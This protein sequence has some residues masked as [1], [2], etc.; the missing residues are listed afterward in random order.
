MAVAPKQQF[1]CKTIVNIQKSGEWRVVWG[2]FFVVCG[3][4]LV[5]KLPHP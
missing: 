1:L 3:W 5:V 2:E 4:W